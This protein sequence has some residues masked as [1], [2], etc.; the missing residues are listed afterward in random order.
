MSIFDVGHQ[1]IILT[2]VLPIAHGMYIYIYIYSIISIILAYK[3]TFFFV[4]VDVDLYIPT[5]AT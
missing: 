1:R 5:R 2:G 3:I 4:I